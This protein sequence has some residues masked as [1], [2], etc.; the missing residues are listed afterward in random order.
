MLVVCLLVLCASATLVHAQEF[1]HTDSVELT[2]DYIVVG[3]GSS[4]SVVAARLAQAGHSVLLLEAGPN[5]SPT[6][7]DLAD[8]QY[9]LSPFASPI[10]GVNRFNFG[11]G[12]GSPDFMDPT[13][14]LR[15][16]PTLLDYNSLN[17]GENQNSDRYYTYPRGTGAGGSSQINGIV[18]GTG[19]LKNYDNIAKLMKDSYWSG[20]NMSRIFKK[21]EN[22][23]LADTYPLDYG[24]GGW[25]QI[26]KGKPENIDQIIFDIAR[27]RRIPF[28]ENE[29]RPGHEAGAFYVDMR[30]GPDGFRSYSY[31]D[32][33]LPTMLDPGNDL[34]VK[35]NSFVEKVLLSKIESVQDD[36][37]EYEAIGVRVYEKPYLHEVAPGGSTIQNNGNGTFTATGPDRN[38]PAAVEYFARKEVILSAGAI[39]TPKLLMLSGI[40]DRDELQGLGLESRVHLP[41]VGKDLADHPEASIVYEM[42][43]AKYLSGSAATVLF[44]SIA[45]IADPSV[46]AQIA[47]TADPAFLEQGP[48]SIVIDWFTDMDQGR[49]KRLPDFHAQSLPSAF[50]KYDIPNVV[51]ILEP[52]NPHQHVDA[53]DYPDPADPL[54]PEGL[55]IYTQRLFGP[56][57]PPAPAS[58]FGWLIE[59][60]DQGEDL[61]GSIKLESADP[62]AKPVIDLA[63]WEDEEGLERLARALLYMREF[64]NHPSMKELA[65]DPN[66]YE[67]VPGEN[68]Q[69]LED[70][71]EY[72]RTWSSWGHHASG[73]AQMGPRDRENAVVDHRLRVYGVEGLRVADTS[74]YP[75]GLLHRFNPDRGAFGIGEAC[76]E[77]IVDPSSVESEFGN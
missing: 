45:A 31:K 18:D 20:K 1:D 4:G 61:K 76:A 55:P 75:K 29:R 5:T 16:N 27:D 40:G 9:I 12:L 11:N 53:L 57:T 63:F 73:T 2:Y 17:Q 69:T 44:P 67:I 64:M 56:L 59:V 43:P 7:A 24:D 23:P 8:L 28:R 52:D 3:A 51:P 49:N 10:G 68:V 62:R 70:M 34:T 71:K 50:I 41:G 38:L 74:I 58:Y 66:N 35:F 54:D 21:M 36:G 48:V 15:A 25:L 30:V 26:K 19:S 72:L 14:G 77:F 6:T 46:Q 42:D 47:A 22:H 39:N 60:L 32:L 37:P 33:L 65:L 13:L